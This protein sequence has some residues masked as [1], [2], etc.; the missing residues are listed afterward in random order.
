VKKASA[1]IC[2]T[3]RISNAHV[4]GNCLVGG[5]NDFESD[6]VGLNAIMY[7]LRLRL[8]D[9]HLCGHHLRGSHSGGN[10]GSYVLNSATIHDDA[11]T[12]VLY[13][14]DGRDWFFYLAWGAFKD[15]LKDKDG[16]DVATSL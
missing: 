2:E 16:H 3:C 4:G 15:K 12:D 5:T 10:N 7:E 11:A 6:I 8:L 14:G 1:K 13:G 9:T